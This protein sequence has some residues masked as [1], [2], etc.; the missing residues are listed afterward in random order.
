MQKQQQQN[1]ST[2]DNIPLGMYDLSK[3]Y[4]TPSLSKIPIFQKQWTVMKKENIWNVTTIWASQIKMTP[5]GSSKCLFHCSIISPLYS[6]DND[7]KTRMGTASRISTQQSKSKYKW[8]GVLLNR[9]FFNTEID[10]MR[11]K[12]NKSWYWTD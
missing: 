12:E 2:W 4:S 10:R 6:H 3:S 7:S 8:K 11:L 5:Q 9:S 1:L